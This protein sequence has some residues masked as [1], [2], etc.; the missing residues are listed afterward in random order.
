MNHAYIIGEYS[1]SLCLFVN[2]LKETDR[3][4]SSSQEDAVFGAVRPDHPCFVLGREEA[5]Q[6]DF[7]QTSPAMADTNPGGSGA[8][9]KDLSND[10]LT[11]QFDSECE[12]QCLV[13]MQ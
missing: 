7:T 3:W 6:Q 9:G 5:Q 4:G 2:K 10:I 11:P 8:Q 13:S 12:L 1:Q